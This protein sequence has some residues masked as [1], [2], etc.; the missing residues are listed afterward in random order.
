MPHLIQ[1][2]GFKRGIVYTS[3]WHNEYSSHESDQTL[4]RLIKPMGANWLQI[5]VTWYQANPSSTSIYPKENNS[6]PSDE[7]LTHVIN[8]AQNLGFN[9]MLKP[10]LDLEENDSHWRGDINL[11]DDVTAWTAWFKDYA[12][13]ISHYASLAQ[14]TKASSFVVGTEL[15]G[16]TRQSVQWRE[17]IRQVRSIYS[18]E[19]TYAAHHDGEWNSID[20]WD[21]LDYIGVDAYFPL[22]TVDH[23]NV[24]QLRENWLPIINNLEKLSQT[25]QKAIVFTEIGYQSRLGASRTP[26]GVSTQNKIIDLQEQADCYQAVFEALSDLKWWR[27]VFWWNWTIFFKQG[28]IHDGGYTANNKP[29]E[30][31]LR[32]NFGASPRQDP[33]SL[34][35]PPVDENK[36]LIIYQPT[37]GPGWQNWSW[38]SSINHL[39]NVLSP[40]GQP[41]TSVVMY[42]WGGFSLHH[43]GIDT[44]PFYYVDIQIF[45]TANTH[46][47]L[48]AYFHDVTDKPMIESVDI[49]ESRYIQGDGFAAGQW[50]VIRIPLVDLGAVNSTISR[51]NLK[52][53]SEV[54]Q[55]AFLLGEIKLLGV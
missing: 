44:T 41:A 12:T 2:D 21:A 28:G 32:Y 23:P 18:G 48:I 3:W 5:I 42:G 25:W 27:G 33:P 36:L 51:F 53:N 14:Q 55:D 38:G 45:V 29:A 4:S 40:N 30:D 47:P 13:F 50:L 22:S 31:I 43:N 10:H 54:L 46:P 9:V 26:W 8:M 1:D 17:V 11:G 35:L 49:F 15:L 39:D 16:T 7:A 6:T 34:P 24:S 37:L 19:L 20:W 52:N